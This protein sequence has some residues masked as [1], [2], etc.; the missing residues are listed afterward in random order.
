MFKINY[1]VGGNKLERV[2]RIGKCND[3]H[4]RDMGEMR[5]GHQEAVN[6][7]SKA[8]ICQAPG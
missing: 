8:S 3:W 5:N 2:D 1:V 4:G 7:T 6:K